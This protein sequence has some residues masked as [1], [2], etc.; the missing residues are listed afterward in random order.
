MNE[1][2][3]PGTYVAGFDCANQ[4]QLGDL[5]NIIP[6]KLRDTSYRSVRLKSRESEVEDEVQTSLIAPVC[7]IRRVENTV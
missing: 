2:E 3:S 4:D 1:T 6:S 5:L 7:D